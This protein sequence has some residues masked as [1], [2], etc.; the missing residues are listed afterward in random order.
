VGQIGE[1]TLQLRGE[2][3]LRQHKD[4]KTGLAHMVGLGAIAYAH[5]LQRP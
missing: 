4:A 1:I 2:A 3:G 5:V